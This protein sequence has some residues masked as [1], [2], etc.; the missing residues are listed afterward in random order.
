MARKLQKAEDTVFNMELRNSGKIRSKN[1]FLVNFF[2]DF[3]FLS[4]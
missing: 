2:P 1:I 3:L 4:S